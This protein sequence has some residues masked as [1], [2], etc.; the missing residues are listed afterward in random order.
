[1]FASVPAGTSYSLEIDDLAM[2]LPDLLVRESQEPGDCQTVIRPSN[3]QG[4]VQVNTTTSAGA[5][6]GTNSPVT[7]QITTFPVGMYYTSFGCG[8]N[9][10]AHG[11]GGG[12]AHS[13][14]Y[15]KRLTTNF[16]EI[17][18]S[19]VAYQGGGEE[20]DYEGGYASLIT[21][22]YGFIHANEGAYSLV[23]AEPVGE[24]DDE[25]DDWPPIA[26]YALGLIPMP[27]VASAVRDFATFGY[28]D[29]RARELDA[30]PKRHLTQSGMK[31][32][33]GA[34]SDHLAQGFA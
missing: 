30:G 17:L 1:M 32:T 22:G 19:A 9:L 15:G 10:P 3:G 2:A 6:T 28:Q 33:Y 20:V 25:G 7:G 8:T 29:F 34:T 26:E 13:L 4:A 21:R 16:P 18:V 23:D 27:G 14:A 11:L 5:P 12:V 31:L 24:T